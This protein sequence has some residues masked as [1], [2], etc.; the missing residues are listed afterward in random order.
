MKLSEIAARL[1]CRMQ[2]DRD[3]DIVGV[4][5][6]EEAV[7]GELTFVSNRKYILHIKHTKASAIILGNDLPDV[8]IPSLRTVNPYL[9]FARSLELFY[10]PHLP[11]RAIHPS[12]II[13]PDVQVGPDPSIGPFVVVGDGCRLGAR[14]TLHAHVVLYPG[15]SLGDDVILHSGV[16]VREQCEIGNRVIIQNGGI[17]GSDGFG[18]APV[19]DGTYH[20]ILQTG[21]VI[22]EDDVEIGA[23][24]TI[25][26]AAVG[27]TR[28][29]RGAKLDNLVQVGH[30]A[31]VGEN[32]VLA[33]QVGVAGSTRIGKNVQAGGQVGFAGHQDVGDGA[34]L[35]AQSGVHGEIAAGAV[36][37]GSPGFDNAQWRRAVIAFPKLPE[38]QR[39]VRAL[40]KEVA[41]LKAG[42]S[43]PQKG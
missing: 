6:I 24:T 11:E 9:A 14:A 37:S 20:K 5:G 16:V 27:C 12:A 38:I 34:I 33:A 2:S 36:I 42:L 13:A 8:P 41:A 19:G 10:T 15:V 4:A 17:I 26:R 39:Q 32:S 31:Q 30:G 40:E 28:I 23:N 1:G 43:E 29:L 18:F 3:I 7:P 35:T 22:I 21:R 25:D